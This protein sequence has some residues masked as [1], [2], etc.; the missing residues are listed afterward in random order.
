MYYTSYCHLHFLWTRT[1]VG[2]VPVLHFGL[3]IIMYLLCICI[4]LLDI[5]S[6]T[7]TV[8]SEMTLSTISTATLVSVCSFMTFL[9]I[10]SLDARIACLVVC[11]ELQMLYRWICEELFLVTFSYTL[12]WIQNCFH[13]IFILHILDSCTTFCEKASVRSTLV[14]LGSFCE[15]FHVQ[16]PVICWVLDLS[17]Q[18]PASTLKVPYISLCP[19]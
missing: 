14:A 16:S 17:G 5:L 13:E 6:T 4:N 8:F 19:D 18:C 2:P 15:Q 1:L 10:M 11:L 9:Q 3:S 12:F 7:S